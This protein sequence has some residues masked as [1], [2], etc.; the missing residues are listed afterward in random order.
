MARLD[1][2]YQDPRINHRLVL[3]Y[4]D[5]TDTTNLVRIVQQ[6]QPYEVYSMGAEGHVAL[7]FESLEYTADVDAMGTPQ[8]L[9][10]IRVLGLEKRTCFYQASTSELYSLVQEF[11]QK[12]SSPFYPRSPYD[13]VYRAIGRGLAW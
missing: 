11:H 2:F 6:A 1:H 4:G 12:E 7:G 8:L 3:H 5:L 10:A 13:V 9:E